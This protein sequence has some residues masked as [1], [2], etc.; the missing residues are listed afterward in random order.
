MLDL[1]KVPPSDQVL[2]THESLRRST[3]A[4]F[5]AMGETQEN[6]KTAA[7]TLVTADLRGVESH[8]VSNM[9]PYY[10]KYYADG[11]I[12]SDH[13]EKIVKEALATAMMDADKGLA[14]ILGP[15]AMSLAIE[16]AKKTGVGVVIMRNAGHSGAIGTHAMM[17]VEHDMIGMCMTAG[18]M[19]VLPTFGAEVRL[20][21]NPIA[22][23]A[24]A[25]KE[26]PF[27][28]DA[29][30]CSV[31]HNK[32]RLAQ[33][34]KV[35]V[36]GGWIADDDG[37]PIMEPHDPPPHDEPLLLPLGSTREM[38]SHK[39]YGFGLFP[40][41]FGT[42]LSGTFPP[43]VTGIRT[44]E[45]YFAAYNIAAFVDVA[46]FKEKMDRMLRTL[47]ETKPA[48]GHDRV[49]Y[50]GIIEHEEEQKRRKYGIPLHKDVV[51]WFEDQGKKY[52]ITELERSKVKA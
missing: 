14:I 3:A 10:L 49:I 2:I 52:R 8:G 4:F 11:S 34:L 13:K 43:M 20:G 30:T 17:A 21:T 36:L 45:H 41:I 26:I 23:A 48:P 6:A 44:N 19:R 25:G 38:G 28:F 27:L 18:G 35:Q 46:E 9:M 50:P 5:E 7:N 51:K 22:V 33:R 24:P 1:F 39:G 29:A 31:A 42:V 16:K 15:K 12:R 40:N 32:I 47:L 37:T